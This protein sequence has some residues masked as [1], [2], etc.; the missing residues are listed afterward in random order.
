ML[1][2]RRAEIDVVRE[3][4]CGVVV[5]VVEETVLGFGVFLGLVR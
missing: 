1:R 4:D 2:L 3:R 5:V